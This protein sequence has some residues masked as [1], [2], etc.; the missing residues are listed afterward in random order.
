M[1]DWKAGELVEV[2][3]RYGVV[4]WDGRPKHEYAML[5]WADDNSE[6]GVNV[7]DIRRVPAGSIKPTLSESEFSGKPNMGG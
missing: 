6:A 1:S 2:D 5:K 3:G 4:F 7:N